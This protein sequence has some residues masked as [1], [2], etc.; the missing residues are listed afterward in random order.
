MTDLMVVL[1]QSARHPVAF[2]KVWQSTHHTQPLACSR[3]NRR[4]PKECIFA[5]E[6]EKTAKRA[7]LVKSVWV[8]KELPE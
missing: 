2:L 8:L 5:Q 4:Q 7:R 3:S 6:Q 1:S